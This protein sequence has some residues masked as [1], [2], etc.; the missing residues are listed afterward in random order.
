[1]RDAAGPGGTV[2]L[3]EQVIPTHDREFLGK[4]VDLEMLLCLAARERTAAEYRDSPIE[5]ACG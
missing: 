3:V 1:M 2:L 4:W 5:P